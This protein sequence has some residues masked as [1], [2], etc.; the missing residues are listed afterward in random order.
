MDFVSRLSLYGIG[1]QYVLSRAAKINPNTVDTMG[2][3]INLVVG[4]QSEVGYAIVLQLIQAFNRLTLDGATGDDLDRYALDRY[5]QQLPRKGAAA[6]VGSATFSRA[7]GAGPAGTILSGTI[8]RSLS[9]FQF[10]TTQQG[11]FTQSTGNLSDTSV[12]VPIRA[13]QAGAL[14]QVGANTINQ[15]Q[16]PNA[17][18]SFDQ[19]IT[20]NNPIATAGGADPEDDPTYRNRIRTFWISA[21]RGILSAIVQGATSVPG[22][23]SAVAFEYIGSNAEPVRLVSLSIADATGTANVQLAQT[24]QQALNDYR[25]AGI[26]VV[27]SPSIPLIVNIALNLSFQAG[28]DTVSIGGQ[29][30]AAVVNFVND[31]PVSGPLYLAQLQSVLQRFVSQGL[32]VSQGTIVSPIGDLVPTAGQ[33]I[34]TTLANVSI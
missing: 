22:I 2:S 28:V 9:G 13:A 30:Q 29:V 26:Q 6:A 25:A 10:I 20:C 14:F 3:D 1:R 27:V 32:I 7:S 33:T 4:G 17:A 12:V 34:R 8:L 18:I 11:S 19:S 5:G 24:V 15:F 31:I 21:R 16:T 23:A